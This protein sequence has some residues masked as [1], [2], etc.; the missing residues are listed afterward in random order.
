MDVR[1]VPF[2]EEHLDRTFEWVNRGDMNV[3]M[4][5]PPRV[6]PEEHRAWFS[7]IS[8]QHIFAIEAAG[9]H[10]GN[11][12]LKD[13]DHQAK[14]AELWIYIGDRENRG[15]GTGSQALALLLDYGFLT[16]ELNRIFVYVVGAER[17]A[18]GLYRRAGFRHEGRLREHLSIN[19]RL[20]DAVYMGI[21]KEEWLAHGK[22]EAGGSST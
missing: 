9:R 5:W 20:Y 17:N 4:N 18:E 21:L 22:Q 13:H 2:T 14:R 7:R 19:G 12:C 10:I 3:L 16:L 8:Q 1:L 11:C 6:T 15:S